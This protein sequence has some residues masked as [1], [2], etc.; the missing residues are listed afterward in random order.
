MPAVAA[1]VAA[2]AIILVLPLQPARV[3][4]REPRG[5]RVLPVHVGVVLGRHAAQA[6]VEAAPGAAAAAAAAAAP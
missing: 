6:G 2:A 4:R 3:P 5:Q 1:A